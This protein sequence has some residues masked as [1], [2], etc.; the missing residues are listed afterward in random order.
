MSV[1]LSDLLMMRGKC[2]RRKHV[3]MND[4]ARCVLSKR[5][6]HYFLVAANSETDLGSFSFSIQSNVLNPSRWKKKVKR[7][8]PIQIEPH[9]SWVG[10]KSVRGFPLKCRQRAGEG[11]SISTRSDMTPC[12]A[13]YRG[14]SLC[15]GI[16]VTM[17]P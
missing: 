11:L 15:P 4:G 6:K 14:A 2:A 12:G 13:A 10:L 17:W 8:G 1:L 16:R 7:K 9:H 5:W 3:N